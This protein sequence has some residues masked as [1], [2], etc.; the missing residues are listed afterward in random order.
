VAPK[1][2][3]LQLS[4]PYTEPIHSKSHLLKR[5][6][7]CHL[8]NTLKH[9]VNKRTAKISTSGIA[10]VSILYGYSRQRRTIGS[11]SATAELLVM[12]VDSGSWLNRPADQQM[13]SKSSYC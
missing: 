13:M 1:N 6:R 4:T 8:A 10:V 12:E 3:I 2:T 9:T 5:R 11:F 7:W